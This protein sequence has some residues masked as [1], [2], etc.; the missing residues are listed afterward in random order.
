M[1]V[2]L[3]AFGRIIAKLWCREKWLFGLIGGS[4]ALVGQGMLK[5]LIAFGCAA[6]LAN[7]VQAVTTLQLNFVANGRLTWRHRVAGSRVGLWHR[8]GRFQLA[9]GREPAPLRRPVPAPGPADRLVG[10]LL[11]PAD[12]RRRGELL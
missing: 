2:E 6:G 5:L 3:S 1:E 10:R 7:A 12:R 4:V 11:E 9:R 8:W